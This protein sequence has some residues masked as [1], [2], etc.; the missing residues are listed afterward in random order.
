MKIVS[1]PAVNNPDQSTLASNPFSTRRI[2]PG[3]LPFLFPNGMTAAQLVERLRGSAWWGQIVGPHG[4]GKSA[5]LATLRPAIE[6]SGR[7]V[8]AIELHDGQRRIAVN[9]EE[10][11]DTDSPAVLAVDGY[12]QLGRLSRWK[13]KRFCRQRGL[14]LLVTAHTPVGLPDLFETTVTVELAQEIV[15]QLQGESPRCV[16]AEDVAQRFS[17]HQGDLRE[18]LFD[19]YDLHERRRRGP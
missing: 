1:G 18:T 11:V 8:Y 12:E 9:L 13:V 2:R 19:L 17:H 14:G 15:D 5:L 4:S 7:S 16:T 3:A 10:A 6:R